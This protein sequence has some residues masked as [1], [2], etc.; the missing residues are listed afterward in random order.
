MV[1]QTCKHHLLSTLNLASGSDFLKDSNTVYYCSRLKL[2]CMYFESV[3]QMIQLWSK[4][5]SAAL[6]ASAWLKLHT[7]QA[8]PQRYENARRVNSQRKLLIYKRGSAYKG[9]HMP[10]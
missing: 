1:V 8:P 2:D 3:R 4:A 10:G 6:A 5:L 9:R 7:T